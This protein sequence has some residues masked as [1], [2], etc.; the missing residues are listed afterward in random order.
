MSLAQKINKQIL[1]EVVPLQS[2]RQRQIVNILS[3][4]LPELLVEFQITTDLRIAHF[5]AQ[6]AHESDGFSTLEEYASGRAYEGRRDLGNVGKGDGVRFKGRGPIQLTGRE[7][8]RKFNEFMKARYLDVPDFI[9]EP[10]QVGALPWGLY[11]AFFFWETRK[12]NAIADRDDLEAVTRKIN[13][14]LNGLKQRA[15]YLSRVK[16]ALARFEA[17][18]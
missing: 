15:L 16:Q 8:Y 10:E 13:G 9:K 4:L 3:E 7:N 11:A 2:A 14:G 5:I 6:L 1:K 18:A 12:L 17:M